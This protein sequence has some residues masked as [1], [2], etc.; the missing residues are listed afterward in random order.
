MRRSL[1]ADSLKIPK[2]KIIQ[3]LIKKSNC[4]N[5]NRYKRYVLISGSILLSYY[6]I[7]NNIT[8][9]IIGSI[10]TT[11]YFTI[12][13][14]FSYV[15]DYLNQLDQWRENEAEYEEK[16]DPPIWNWKIINYTRHLAIV[17]SLLACITQDIGDF[18][19]G[20]FYLGN[21]IQF[22]SIG[23]KIKNDKSTKNLISCFMDLVS[24]ILFTINKFY[25][26]IMIISIGTYIYIISEII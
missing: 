15:E 8:C 24:I 18:N 11:S 13:L 14:G 16:I 17:F 23:L 26:S 1:S 25:N 2:E 10:L 5:I 6:S 4:R 20:Y 12:N 9:E 21:C 7:S 22:L 3:I 19:D